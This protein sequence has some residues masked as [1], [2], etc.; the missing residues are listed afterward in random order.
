M[1][2]RYQAGWGTGLDSELLEELLTSA[3]TDFESGRL[4]PS[5]EISVGSQIAKGK[6]TAL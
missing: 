5:T 3:C 1:V 2:I 4:R 6:G